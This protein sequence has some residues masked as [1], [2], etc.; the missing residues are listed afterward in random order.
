MAQRQGGDGLLRWLA[1]GLAVGAVVLGL[2]V[3]AYAIGY[4]RGKGHAG[5]SGA[6]PTTTQAA[7]TTPTTTQAA[8]ATTTAPTESPAQLVAR[9]KVL[10]GSDGCSGCHSL[11]GA[12]G[13]G[14]TVKG[15]AGGTTT[16]TDGT[17]VTADDAYL[18]RSITEPD[19]QIVKGYQ[20]GIMSAA[21]A[22]FGLAGKPA[23]VQALVAFLKA[24]R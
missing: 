21:V 20:P 19:A 24:Q 11:S 16:L 7:P 13:A 6:K 2:V 4:H 12:A 10:F 18:S 5:P 17:T 8:P 14:P 9:G 1:G 3:A 22:G 15:L 23:D